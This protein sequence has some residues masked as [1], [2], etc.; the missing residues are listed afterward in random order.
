[1]WKQGITIK[2]KGK[3]N[4]KLEGYILLFKILGKKQKSKTKL[5]K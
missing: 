5:Y 2:F 3:K 1:M 4:V